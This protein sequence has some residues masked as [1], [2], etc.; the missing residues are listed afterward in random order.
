MEI[1]S[2]WRSI[3]R[4]CVPSHIFVLWGVLH[5]PVV[6]YVKNP[7]PARLLA[8]LGAWNFWP[9]S[10]QRD[11]EFATTE[12]HHTSIIAHFWD[13][14]LNAKLFQE[15]FIPLLLYAVI[16]ELVN[17]FLIQVFLLLN[18]SFVRTVDKQSDRSALPPVSSASKES[19]RC[20][21]HA[22]MDIITA[23]RYIWEEAVWDFCSPNYK[24]SIGIQA[25]AY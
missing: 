11:L 19:N 8:N 6:F 22:A 4:L 5:K 17:E 18:F 7:F 23:S 13:V 21:S 25:A 20:S 9:W 10:Q 2:L 14:C 12:F 3:S 15:R 24:Y 16:N 1:P